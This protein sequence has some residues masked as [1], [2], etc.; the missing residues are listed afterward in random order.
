MPRRRNPTP[1]YRLHSPTGKAV[2]TVYL[3]EGTRKDFVLRDYGSPESHAEYGRICALVAANGGVY[4]A[5]ADGATVAE[6]LLAYWRHTERYYADPA[7]GR[8][9]S[10][11]DNVRL[12]LRPVR[13]LYAL[14][15]VSAFGPKDLRAVCDRMVFGGLSRK[16]VNRRVG[17][18]RRVFR[19]GVGEDLVPPEVYQ[20]L[21]AV[22]GLR[23]G[24]TE[25]PDLAPRPAR[26][27]GPCRSRPAPP[28]AGRGGAGEAPADDRGAVRGVGGHAAPGRGPVE[29]RGLG[30]PSGGP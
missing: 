13:E 9:T 3:P 16:E 7:T 24:R 28:A 29:P 21:Q 5:A 1:P 2:T 25:A 10:F 26:R 30:V 23:A 14:T 15:R 22:E 19:W 6:L 4:P 27:P 18:V 8:S 12:A 11:L 17:I 20:K